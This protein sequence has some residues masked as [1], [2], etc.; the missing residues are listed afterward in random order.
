MR[1]QL[2][3]GVVSLALLCGT[4]GEAP[5]RPAATADAA[6]SLEATAGAT[7]NPAELAAQ[8]AASDVPQL[9]ARVAAYDQALDDLRG[10]HGRLEQQLSSLAR[11]LDG[12]E[13]GDQATA[14]ALQ[15]QLADLRVEVDAL[16]GHLT[17]LKEA[18]SLFVDELAR[19]RLSMGAPDD[20]R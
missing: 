17:Q 15:S 3:P 19:R 9:E 5:E 18:R 14:R 4:C 8:A 12:R 13:A 11:Q 1:R 20:S 10:D 2:A 16:L 6:T 7:A